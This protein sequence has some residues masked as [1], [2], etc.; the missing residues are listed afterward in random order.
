MDT[1]AKKIN[2]NGGCPE[3][4]LGRPFVGT[5]TGRLTDRCKLIVEN[6]ATYNLFKKATL[7]AVAFG[8]LAGASGCA[9]IGPRAVA[10]NRTDYNSVVQRTDD[11]EILLNLVRL[12]YRDTPVFL[13]IPSITSQFNFGGSIGATATVNSQVTGLTPAHSIGLDT[14]LNYTEVPTVTY[15]PL[16]GEE[17]VQRVLSPISLE[18][19]MLLTHSGWSIEDVFRLLVQRLNGVRNAPSASGPTPQTAPEF[20]DFLRA[21]KLLRE[22][23]LR[24]AVEILYE[25][26][27]GQPVYF[28]HIDEKALNW[29][30]TRELTRLLSLAPG[31]TR[32]ILTNQ[33]LV[34]NPD[35]LTVEPRS[36]GGVFFY[37]SQSVEVPKKDQDLGRVTVTKSSTGQTF[38]WTQLTGDLLR[39]RSQAEQ[40]KDAA[41][42]VFYRGSWFYIDESDLASKTTFSLLSQIFALQ[43][44]K[45]KTV[46]P[47]LTLPVGR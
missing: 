18:T 36:L 39:V 46:T 29:P 7:L 41:V 37:L 3:P 24:N 16:Q 20:R 30:E 32:Y 40:P 34:E 12:K 8:A 2:D 44:G 22:L 1:N 6:R 23:Q 26:K 42:A 43:A 21:A 47:V 13:Q 15:V 25:L 33:L 35:S 4:I 31:R 45:S 10:V 14:R 5:R 11:Q 28:L 19:M 9:F 27:N 38:D 17:F